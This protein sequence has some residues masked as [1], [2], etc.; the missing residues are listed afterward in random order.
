MMMAMMKRTWMS[1]WKGETEEAMSNFVDFRQEGELANETAQNSRPNSW[2]VTKS[3]RFE[4]ISNAV[5]AKHAKPSSFSSFFAL[6]E[7]FT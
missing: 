4:P 1:I 5:S 7:T 3:N 2:Q 6:A